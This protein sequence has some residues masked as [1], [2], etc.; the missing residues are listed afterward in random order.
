[1]VF[2]SIPGLNFTRLKTAFSIFEYTH[3]Q[4]HKWHVSKV[5]CI[6]NTSLFVQ[7]C[8]VLLIA[9]ADYCQCLFGFFKMKVC[10]FNVSL[11]QSS[12]CSSRQHVPL[13]QRVQSGYESDVPSWEVEKSLNY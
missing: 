1:M 6:K 11:L 12:D 2:C 10:L 13:S 9:V 5:P 7:M 4:K 8:E 3:L